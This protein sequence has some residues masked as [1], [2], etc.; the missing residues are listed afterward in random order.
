M[1]DV[2]YLYELRDRV[3]T[4]DFERALRQQLQDAGVLGDYWVFPG[5]SVDRSLFA[6]CYPVL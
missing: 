2:K 4:G 6:E 1:S 5:G 3:I